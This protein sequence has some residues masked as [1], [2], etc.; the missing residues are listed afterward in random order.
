MDFRKPRDAAFLFCI[1]RCK[2]YIEANH[3]GSEWSVYADEGMIKL[4]VSNADI[5]SDWP[6]HGLV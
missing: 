5:Q 3:L 4:G 2:N 6:F 1:H